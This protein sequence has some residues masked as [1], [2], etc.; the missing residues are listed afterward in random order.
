MTFPAFF[1]AAP[2]IRMRDP[3]SAF[4][5]SAED[6]VIEYGYA[7]AVKLA[8]HSCPTVAGAWLMLARGLRALWGDET[9]ERGAVRVAFPDARDEV[10]T[11]VMA[12]IATLVTGAT[13]R[14][15]FKGLGGRF[16]RRGLLEFGMG[17]DATMR[18]ERPET[19]KAVEMT[20]STAGIPADPEMG[21]LLQ[22]SLSGA[23]DAGDA[24]RFAELWQDRVRRILVEHADDEDMIIVRSV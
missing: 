9:P 14:D 11:G 5:G 24:S 1:D 18:L 22:R 10:V 2:R 16:D 21:V 19:G 7:D 6:G 3:L 8:G 12:G 15:G 23:G 17:N 13:D 20:Y 4:L